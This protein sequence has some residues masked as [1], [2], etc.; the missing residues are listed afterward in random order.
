MSVFTVK[1]RPATFGDKE[2]IEF[3]KQLEQFAEMSEVPF[4]QV[5]YGRTIKFI[6][7]DCE[8]EQF[9]DK[10]EVD[11]IICRS[12][13][14]GFEYYVANISRVTHIFYNPE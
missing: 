2:Q 6:C 10:P 12:C 3:I 14:C 11:T 1:G 8:F 7:P 9:V 4:K 5:A 13:G